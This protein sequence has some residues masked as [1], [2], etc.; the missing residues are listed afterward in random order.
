MR[1]RS[2]HG[3]LLLFAALAVWG[4]LGV[5]P[6]RA[7]DAPQPPAQPQP[8]QPKPA[9][10]Q[11]ALPPRP[12]P[13]SV[14]RPTPPRIKV[15]SVKVHGANQLGAG[16]VISILGTRASSWLPWGRK[17]YFDRAVFN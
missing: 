12:D 17:R 3:P 8:A 10:Q 7:Q 16:R 11:P 1:A 5:A 6:A 13:K 4:T 9:A 2:V 14:A 15:T